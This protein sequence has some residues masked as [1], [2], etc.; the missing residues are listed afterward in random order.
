MLH[1]QGNIHKW[2]PNFLS[3]FVC[4][5]PCSIKCTVP[6]YWCPNFMESIGTPNPNKVGHHLKY[7]CPLKP[8][9]IC[10]IVS[11]DTHSPLSNTSRDWGRTNKTYT[12]YSDP[13]TLRLLV[14]LTMLLGYVVCCTCAWYVVQVQ[15]RWNGGDYRD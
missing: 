6:Y 3:F 15:A 12:L 13:F 4:V 8:E 2:C 7:G 1:R 9:R 10:Q 14:V 11:I 5:L